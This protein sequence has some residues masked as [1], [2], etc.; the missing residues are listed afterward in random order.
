MKIK[1]TYKYDIHK[2]VE[3]QLTTKKFLKKVKKF[4]YKRKK[5]QNGEILYVAKVRKISNNQIVTSAAYYGMDVSPLKLFINFNNNSEDIFL[6]E[7]LSLDALIEYLLHKPN[8]NDNIYAFKI[9]YKDFKICKIESFYRH[10]DEFNIYIF[11]E[12]DEKFNVWK[13]LYIP[14]GSSD[15]RGC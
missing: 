13:S 14:Y 7:A 2:I 8:K 5:L 15:E 4:L 6:A 9:F 12:D 3:A 10:E 11:D 1:S